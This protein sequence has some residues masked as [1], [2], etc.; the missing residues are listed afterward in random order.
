MPPKEVPL[1]FDMDDYL[2]REWNVPKMTP[3][4]MAKNIWLAHNDPMDDDGGSTKVRLFNEELARDKKKAFAKFDNELDAEMA[5]YEEDAMRDLGLAV[6]KKE[7]S[8]PKTAPMAKR[9]ATGVSTLKA[10]SAASALSNPSRPSFAAGTG[11]ATTKSR[12]PTG[13]VSSK[14]TIKP[15][16]DTPAPRQALA[17]T[18][19]RSTIG[20]AQGRAGRVAPAARKPISNVT[21][22]APFSA[23]ARRVA[24]ATA[25][26]P[27]PVTARSRSALSRSSSTATDATLVA[28]SEP[29]DQFRRIAEMELAIQ[30][31]DLTNSIDDDDEAWANSFNSQLQMDD[32]EDDFQMKLPEGF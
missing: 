7:T 15:L 29:E 1:P 19:S 4:E 23:A 3:Q 18:A 30:L 25:S 28:D 5:S 21:K 12:A 6:P 26:R 24:P 20:Y 32:D 2:P 11:T 31:E 16:A 9:S 10:R 27:A 17:S 22:P 8:K 14:K 13:L